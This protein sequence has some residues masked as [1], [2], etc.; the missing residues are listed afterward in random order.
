MSRK[1]SINQTHE[2]NMEILVRL[3]KKAIASGKTKYITFEKG[4]AAE[5]YK[6]MCWIIDRS[7]KWRA[8][9][10]AMITKEMERLGMR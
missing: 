7:P 8:E 10:S 1:N 4:E 6:I 9:G 5:Q 3:A 2:E